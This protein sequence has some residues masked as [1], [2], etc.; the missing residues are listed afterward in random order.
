MLQRPDLS[1]ENYRLAIETIDRSTRAQAKLID[2]ILDVSRIVSGKLRLAVR[3]TEVGPIVQAAVES[4][5]PA[6][7]AKG[8]VLD[9]RLPPQPTQ[10]SGDPD[11][12][13]QVVWNLVS[14]AIKFT[15]AG[16]RVDVDVTCSGGLATIQVRDNGRGIVPELLPHVFER[17]WQ[18]ESS[19]T[20]R[21]GGLGL[22]LAIVRH[23]VELHGGS[24][25]VDSDGPEHGATFTVRLP[26]V[27]ITRAEQ[28]LR[29]PPAPRRLAGVRVLIVDDEVDAQEVARR[30]LE[31]SGVEVRTAGSTRDALEILEQWAPTVL[32]SDIAMPEEDGYALIRRLRGREATGGGH[33]PALA[34]TALARAEDRSRV[35]AA[36]FDGYIAKPVSYSALIDA[37]AAA[38]TRSAAH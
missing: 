17:F 14:N 20:R 7:A 30:M 9:V 6:A 15:R 2:D 36:G 12:L 18:A 35:L 16:E 10:V 37:V 21:H 27:T 26:A 24:V 29:P 13:Q 11:R 38:V 28:P 4:M 22:G 3:P 8:V 5:R 34:F 23:L 25:A 19:T 1:D 31:L 32:V 33:M